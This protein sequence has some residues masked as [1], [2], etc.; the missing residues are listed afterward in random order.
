VIDREQV[1]RV[2]GS[3]FLGVW[4]DAVLKLRS[5]INQV[6]VKIRR[7]L[8]VLGRAGQIWMSVSLS[9]FIIVWSCHISSTV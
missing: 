8:G 2:E 4:V 6:E 5:H 7:L 9:H 3:K 1:R